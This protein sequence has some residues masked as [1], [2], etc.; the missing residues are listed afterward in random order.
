MEYKQ[1]ALAT[2][3]NLTN[4]ESKLYKENKCLKVVVKV[5][6]KN[7]ETKFALPNI[8][9]HHKVIVIQINAV[10]SKN[11]ALF[12]TI[13][14]FSILVSISFSLLLLDTKVQVSFSGCQYSMHIVT[15]HCWKSN[16][17]HDSIVRGRPEVLSLV[18]S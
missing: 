18:L 10:F 13:F 11:S 12:I 4:T 7:S 9:I 2:G 3:G 17:F 14:Q 5:T 15:H 1:C 6:W 8:K 16:T